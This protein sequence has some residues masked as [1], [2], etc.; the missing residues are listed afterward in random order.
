MTFSGHLVIR[1]RDGARV[2][3]SSLAGVHRAT[4]N[5]HAISPILCL[6]SRIAKSYYEKWGGTGCPNQPVRADLPG[7]DRMTASVGVLDALG[8]RQ[9]AGR[10]C[11][12]TNVFS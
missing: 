2:I 11:Q 8:N 3:E 5:D 10:R 12:W 1:Q 9:R 4:P 6:V 7:E